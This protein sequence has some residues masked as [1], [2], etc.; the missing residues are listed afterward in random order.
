MRTPRQELTDPI[1]STNGVLLFNFKFYTDNNGQVNIHDSH[2]EVGFSAE[3]AF[4]PITQV[5]IVTLGLGDPENKVREII[6][7]LSGL[8]NELM[9]MTS[10][11]D[12]VGE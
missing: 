3:W 1:T 11:Y 10:A 6:T 4:D 8:R 2:L 12:M 9:Q 5:V 7:Y